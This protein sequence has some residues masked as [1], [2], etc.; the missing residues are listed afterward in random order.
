MVLIMM[1]YLLLFLFASPAVAEVITDG[2]LG[3]RVELTGK[4]FAITPDLGEQMGANLFHSFDRFSLHADE[5]ATFSGNTQVHNIIARVT[6]GQLSTIDGVLRSTVPDA[7]LYLMNPAGIMFGKNAQLDVQGGFHATTADELRFSDGAVFS[8]TPHAAELLTVAPLHS[9]GFLSDSPAPIQLQD[10]YL[11]VPERH[12]L[13]LIGGAL[14]LKG[15]NLTDAHGELVF[16]GEVGFFQFPRQ[17]YTTQL[18]TPSG[19]IYLA[20]LASSGE[21]IIQEDAFTVTA[22]K[23]ANILLDHAEVS[24]SGNGQGHIFVRGADL[25]LN[26]GRLSNPTYGQ[27]DG[28]EINV[29]ARDVL[30]AGTPTSSFISSNSYNSGNGGLIYITADNLELRGGAISTSI[31]KAGNGGNITIRVKDKLKLTNPTPEFLKFASI[32]SD[33][34]SME[35]TSGKSGDISVTAKSIEIHEVASISSVSYGYGGTGNI[36]VIADDIII[37]GTKL[38]DGWQHNSSINTSSYLGSEFTKSFGREGKGGDVGQINITTRYLT[39]SETGLMLSDA[40]SGKAGQINIRAEEINILNGG[41]IASSTFGEGLGGRISITTQRLNI[42]ENDP[43]RR[44]PSGI[45]TD[46]VSDQDNAGNSGDLHIQ[47]DRLNVLE[48]SVITSSTQNAVGGNIYLAAAQLYLRGGEITTSVKGG[49]GNGGDINVTDAMMIIN[50]GKIVAQADAGKGGNIRLVTQHLIP[51][52]ESLISASSRVGVDGNIFIS[53][54]TNDLSGQVLNLSTEFIDGTALLPRSC[55]ARI[56]DQRPSEFVRPFS[57]TMR[58]SAV[59]PSPEDLAP[60]NLLD[61]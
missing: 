35:E 23:L 46:S 37:T 5:S 32:F 28:G 20:S 8:A 16:D 30:I 33:N 44:F 49:I 42:S 51:S 19:R 55:A 60:S 2:S 26:H 41:N 24:S 45:Y 48:N 54:P 34:F 6:G 14:T 17:V 61:H 27:Y 43:N 52:T 3:A 29:Y 56:A 1:K 9:F 12:V 25:T 50:D 40:Y 4:H 22:A 11:S 10:S 36:D 53:S 7:D 47:T 58:H 31:Y 13:S 15:E 59:K 38:L 39:L 57:L 21:A 18:K